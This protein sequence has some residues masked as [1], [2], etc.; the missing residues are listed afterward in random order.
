MKRGKKYL[1]AFKLVDKSVRYSGLDAIKLAKKTT[2]TK[3]D[4]TVEV[5][6]RLNVDPKK[7]DQNIRGAISLPHGTGKS[8]RVVVMAPTDLAKEALEAGADFAGE[9]E[10]LEKING[11]WLDFDVLIATPEMMPKLG[12]LGRVLGPKGLMPNPRTGTVT[13]EIKKTVEEFKAGKI[14]YRN[15]KVGNIH[16]PIGKVSFDDKKLHENLLTLYQQLVSLRPA[17]VKGTYV[18]SITISTTMGPGVPV[19]EDLIIK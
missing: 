14:E 19:A 6:I 15:D 18:K 5:A 3:F 9:A 11:G 7:A 17:S 13:T 16:A 8:V 4:S 1:E 2:T 10:L 12:R